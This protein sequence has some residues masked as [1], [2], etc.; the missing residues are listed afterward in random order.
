MIVTPVLVSFFFVLLV[1]SYYRDSIYQTAAT[2][3]FLGHVFVSL[4][5]VP[6]LPYRW[7]FGNFHEVALALI[8]GEPITASTTVTT[9]GVIQG[10]FYIF[11]PA[12]EETI[13]IFNG[14]FAVLIVFPIISL[15]RELYGWLPKQHYGVM[16][17]VLFLPLPF[18]ILSLPMREAL[19]TLL[20]FTILATTIKTINKTNI[21]YL[22][23]VAPMWV[24]L[25]YMR[26]ELA[27]IAVVGIAAAILT[28]I[29]QKIDTRVSISKVVLLAGPLGLFGVA[30]F[31]EF[32]YS[33]DQANS[34]LAWRSRGGAVYLEGMQY[35]SWFDFILVAPAR[36]LYFQFAPFPLHIEQVSHLFGFSMSI[37]VILLFVSAARSL[38]N[39]EFDLAVGVLL[40]TIYVAGIVGYGLINSNYGTNVRHRIVFDFLLV[41]LAAPVIYQWELRLRNWV[42]EFPSHSNDN[43]TKNNKAQKVDYNISTEGQNPKQTR[44]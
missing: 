22:I 5:I 36:G 25:F 9:F 40:I 2:V 43:N 10:I 14:L 35:G 31:A 16:M 7:D 33:L 37:V 20:F 11:F 15:C 13:A 39:C 34:E 21:R 17:L 27:L 6:A 44:E 1:T 28:K 3:A 38:Y 23:F 8:S 26:P 32:L 42:G 12:Q 18:Y 24:L 19:S 4:V 30:L 29:I 41:I